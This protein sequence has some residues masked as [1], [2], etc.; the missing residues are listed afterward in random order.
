[1]DSPSNQSKQVS[2]LISKLEEDRA[3]LLEQ[4]DKGKWNSFR[5]DLA[6]LE[7]ELGQLLNSAV[8]SMEGKD[9]S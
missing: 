9:N 7:R 6:A 8:D 2:S 4:I 3:F 1:M 5:S